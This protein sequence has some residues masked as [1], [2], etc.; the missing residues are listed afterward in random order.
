M[1]TLGKVLVSTIKMVDHALQESS[2]T[3]Q[4]KKAVLLVSGT[5]LVVLISMVSAI[6]AL[7]W[8]LR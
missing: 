4:E 2:L 6:A 7:K 3:K 5:V 8:F 1:S